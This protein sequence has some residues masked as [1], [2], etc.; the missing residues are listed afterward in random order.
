MADPG[1]LSETIVSD[2]GLKTGLT[3]P[4]EK[5]GAFSDFLGT[6]GGGA[7]GSAGIQGLGALL[8]AKFTAKTE[9]E[10]RKRAALIA[11]AKMIQEG[12]R[13]QGEML[14]S[15]IRGGVSQTLNT[16]SAALG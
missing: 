4:V 1:A 6:A 8:Q 3:P 9:E 10:E 7:I 2:T 14:T 11:Q 15:G 13:T 16:L 12:G 5:P